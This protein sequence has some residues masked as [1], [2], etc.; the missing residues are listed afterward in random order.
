MDLAEYLSGK[1]EKSQSENRYF[2]NSL[3]LLCCTV[4]IERGPHSLPNAASEVKEV[5]ESEGHGGSVTN[6]NIRPTEREVW[7][8]RKRSVLG[9]A[10]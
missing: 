7:E 6:S 8:S 3:L 1:K 2:D 4:S 10:D 9:A 5:K